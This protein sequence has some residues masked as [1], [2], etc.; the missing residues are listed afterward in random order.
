MLALPAGRFVWAVSRSRW[1]LL[2]AIPFLL[3][4][5]ALWEYHSLIVSSI[6]LTMNYV[7]MACLLALTLAMPPVPRSVRRICAPVAVVGAYSYSIYLYHVSI[8]VYLGRNLIPPGGCTGF[9]LYL[10]V[11]V[12]VGIVMAFLIEVPSLRLRD[13]LFTSWKLRNAGPAAAESAVSRNEVVR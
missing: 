9:L 8:G 13:A 5:S 6:G 1:L 3:L 2:M 12:V 4:P 10:V 7:A 11:S